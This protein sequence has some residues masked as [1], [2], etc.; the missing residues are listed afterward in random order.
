MIYVCPYCGSSLPK[1]LQDGICICNNCGGLFDSSQQSRLL[2]A[3]WIAR[4]K[5][6]TIDEMVKKFC[7]SK[8][9]AAMVDQKINID[10]MS[11]EEF[12]TYL[13]EIRVPTRCYMSVQ[14]LS[15]A[16]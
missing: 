8:A 4:K 1:A 12:L 6:Y 7:L 14:A 11:H 9:E 3:A 2:S 16:P 5:H 15:E 10:L 13:R